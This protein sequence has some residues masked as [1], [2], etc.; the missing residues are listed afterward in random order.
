MLTNF[1]RVHEAS[2]AINNLVPPVF[3][4]FEP[5][6]KHQSEGFGDT[7]DGSEIRR[8]PVDVGSISQYLPR[9]F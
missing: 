8:S 1:A 6:K 5:T 7:V 4:H 9:V 2:E 3:E